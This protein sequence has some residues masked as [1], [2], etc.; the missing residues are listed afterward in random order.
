MYKAIIF[1]SAIFLLAI[2]A[3]SFAYPSPPPAA[4]SGST[5]PGAG[6]NNMFGCYQSLSTV[7]GNLRVVRDSIQNQTNSMKTMASLD[8]LNTSLS[9][10]YQE[11]ALPSNT[12]TTD[13]SIPELSCDQYITNIK[14][15]MDSIINGWI[16][17]SGTINNVGTLAQMIPIAA[18]ACSNN[19]NR[20]LTQLPV[21]VLLVE[22]PLTQNNSKAPLQIRVFKCFN[23]LKVLI[24]DIKALVNAIHTKSL[25]DTLKDAVL[26]IKAAVSIIGDCRISASVEQAIQNNSLCIEQIEIIE[27]SLTLMV[28]EM[29][30]K[31][32]TISEVAEQLFNIYVQDGQAFMQNCGMQTLKGSYDS[33]CIDELL[34]ILKDLIAAVIDY[35]DNENWES[36]IQDLLKKFSDT[37][38]DCETTPS[39]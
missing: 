10:L 7:I 11:C 27:P 25:G 5:G 38:N 1:T 17:L 8:T 35:E 9:N 36:E 26:I 19:N 37:L 24:P 32:F 2:T 4:S 18:A 14:A 6:N 22:V 16:N 29:E 12:F 30:T 28:E 34:T 13:H 23:D 15:L 20:L 21:E 33:E 3:N 39:F 31:K